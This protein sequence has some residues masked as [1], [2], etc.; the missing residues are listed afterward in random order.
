MKILLKTIPQNWLLCFGNSLCGVSSEVTLCV[1]WLSA[2]LKTLYM[3]ALGRA[4]KILEL[5]HRLGQNFR[6]LVGPG[7]SCTYNFSRKG[8]LY[9]Q[10]WIYFMT[11]NFTFSLFWFDTKQINM[12]K[13]EMS[14]KHFF[15]NIKTTLL[16]FIQ[17]ITC[18]KF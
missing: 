6:A 12:F 7:S 18:F 10:L 5:M 1:A 17:I 11:P 2:W 8:V 14:F 9:P 3:R 16:Y 15:I 13:K 4:C